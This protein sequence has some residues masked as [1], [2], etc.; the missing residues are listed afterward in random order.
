M[1]QWDVCSAGRKVCSVHRIKVSSVPRTTVHLHFTGRETTA[2]W[3]NHG[4]TGREIMVLSRVLRGRV[5][6]LGSRWPAH[7]SWPAPVTHPDN[8]TLC[9]NMYCRA[10]T[11]TELQMT[12]HHCTA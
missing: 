9:S 11:T 10:L 1:V 2:V 5:G 7:V 12:N 8:P 6:Q 4:F 3:S